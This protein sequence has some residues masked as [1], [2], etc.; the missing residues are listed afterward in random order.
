MSGGI[1]TVTAA[2]ETDDTATPVLAGIEALRWQ[3]RPERRDLTIDRVEDIAFTPMPARVRNELI[4]RTYGDLA[5][6]MAE[7]FGTGDATWTVLGQWASHTVGDALTLPIPGLDLIISRAFGDGN[8]DVFADI[9]RAHVAFLDTVGLAGSDDDP[10]DVWAA[11]E[12]ALRANLISPPGTPGG[13]LGGSWGAWR[14]DSRNRDL[15]RFEMPLVL[16]FRAYHRALQ[17]DDPEE[18]SRHLLLGNCLLALHEQRLVAAALTVGFRSWLRTLTTPWRFLQSRH[19]WRLHDP[20]RFRLWLEHRWIRFATRF[21]VGVETPDGTIKAGRPVPSGEAPIEVD[22]RPGPIGPWPIERLAAMDAD[23][24]LPRVLGDLEVDGR[25]SVCWN[26]VRDRVAFIAGLFVEH[27]RAGF[28]FDDDGRVIRPEPWDGLDA[29]LA[30]LRTHLDAGTVPTSATGPAAAHADQGPAPP[31]RAAVGWTDERL[32]ELRR[33]PAHP[34]L[35]LPPDIR[36]SHLTDPEF[37]HHFQPVADDLDERLAFIRQPGR[38]LD[39]DTCRRARRLFQQSPTIGFF[40]LLFR[41]LPD[42]YA[43][44]PGAL[45]LGRGSR[46]TDDPFRRAGETAQFVMDLLERPAGW[47]D[48]VLV[49]GG[50]AHGSVLGV[51]KLHAMVAH[52]LARHRWTDRGL[53]VAFNQEDMLGAALTFAVPPLEMMEELGIA[54]AADDC[55]AYLRFWLGIGYLLGAPWEAITVEGRPMRADEARAMAELIRRR[56]RARSFDG[57]RLGEALV[58][59]I[60]D[61]FPRFFVWMVTGFFQVVGDDDVTATLLIADGHG[62]RRAAA[63]TAVFRFL[64]RWR[65]T[66]WPTVV[67]TRVVGHR[68]LRP[69]RQQGRTRPYRRPLDAIDRERL[70]REDRQIDVWPVNCGARSG[71]TRGPGSR[72]RRVRPTGRRPPR[73][74][75]RRRGSRRRPRQGPARR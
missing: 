38:H 32:D 74:R 62:R 2:Q 1:A 16:G 49:P 41:S 34:R 27:Q 50:P 69:F 21:L 45:V 9:A 24:L 40:G 73:G 25:A 56:H 30:T 55:D 43:A 46:L 68:F 54:P 64:L 52:H 61:G 22:R 48:G 37:D 47:D 5:Q 65:L 36:F 29:G 15:P 58:E 14:S 67:L 13:G 57:V 39:A 72:R 3:P 23:E 53:G 7:L 8:R 71:R 6:A 70:G 12:E 66:R 18:R 44:A 4:T 28:W 63:M 60:A 17:T 11:C 35:D 59:G 31:D 26:D 75:S 19:G 51:H 33:R 20:G 10:D 42:S